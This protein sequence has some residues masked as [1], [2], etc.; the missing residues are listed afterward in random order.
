MD[1]EKIAQ[2]IQS[3]LTLR[4]RVLSSLQDK[5]LNKKELIQTVALSPVQYANRKEKVSNWTIDETISLAE[6]LGLGSKAASDIKRLSSLLQFL[7]EQ[8][9]RGLLRQAGLDRKKMVLR[10]RNYNLWKA[11]ELHRLAMVCSM[12]GSMQATKRT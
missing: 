5:S 4:A 11:D 8:T 6:R 2:L 3:Y 7:P 9:S 10:Q 1:T 12:G